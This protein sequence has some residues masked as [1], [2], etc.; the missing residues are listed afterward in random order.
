MVKKLPQHQL[1]PNMLISLRTAQEGSHQE[2]GL[3]GPNAQDW[4][5]AL[6]PTSFMT[7]ATMEQ[8]S[9]S[10]WGRNE[11]SQAHWKHSKFFLL[12]LFCH[13]VLSSSIYTSLLQSYHSLLSFIG[14]FCVCAS[15]GD[16]YAFLVCLIYPPQSFLLLFL[17]FFLL[18]FCLNPGSSPQFC[19]LRKFTLCLFP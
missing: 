12:L 18:W 1:L 5:S 3:W 14:V 10:Q 19:R 2:Q 4:I 8:C 6:S 7:E 13:Y 17:S 15:I 9:K 11:M 16:N